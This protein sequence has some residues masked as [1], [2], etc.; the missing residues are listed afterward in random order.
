MNNTNFGAI[1][2]KI[3]LDK[4]MDYTIIRIFQER[5]LSD[6]ETLHHL[7]ELERTQILQ[8]FALAVLKIPYKSSSII[9]T[10]FITKKPI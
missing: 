6:L 4:K 7:W 1:H 9:N 2:Y 5:S 3:L 10:Y 8:S